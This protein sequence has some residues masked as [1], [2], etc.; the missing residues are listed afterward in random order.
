MKTK[1]VTENFFWRFGGKP[2]GKI[3]YLSFR[4]KA[5]RKSRKNGGLMLSTSFE[6]IGV[7]KMSRG[8]GKYRFP[9]GFQCYN[10]SL[11]LKTRKL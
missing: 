10:C 2:D 9:N 1:V 3:E 11:R 7:L 8:C 5:K 4:L 6:G